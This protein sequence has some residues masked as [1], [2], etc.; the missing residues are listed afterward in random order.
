MKIITFEKK[1]YYVNKD[2][3]D[4]ELVCLIFNLHIK[5]K[6]SEEISKDNFLVYRNITNGKVQFTVHQKY[7]FVTLVHP[8]YPILYQM[9]IKDI[10]KLKDDIYGE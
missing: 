1:K 9:D 6:N 8:L 3:T 7:F 5:D 4:Q 10:K 2:Y